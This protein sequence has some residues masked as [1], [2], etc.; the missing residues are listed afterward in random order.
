MERP[1][2]EKTCPQCGEIMKVLLF[3]GVQPDGYVC[4]RCEVWF[5]DELK[6]LAQV[7]FWKGGEP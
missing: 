5:N 7:L 1:K 6:P 3:L 4:E 2:E